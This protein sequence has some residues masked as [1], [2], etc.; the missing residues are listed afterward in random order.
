MFKNYALI[1]SQE[2]FDFQFTCIYESSIAIEINLLLLTEIN[3]K[4]V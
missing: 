2:V 3:V 4:R 1:L